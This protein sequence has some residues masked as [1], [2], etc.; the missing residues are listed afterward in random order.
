MPKAMP[1]S[2]ESKLVGVTP[3]RFTVL[4]GALS[5]IAG[6]GN[7]LLHPSSAELVRASAAAAHTLGPAPREHDSD[8]AHRQLV[9]R[10]NAGL[11][12][13]FVPAAG[14]ALDTAAA[15]RPIVLPLLTGAVGVAAASL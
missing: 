11:L 15:A 14:R 3:A 5:V 13:A 1:V 7:A 8:G 4:S 2:I 9:K 6:D 10:S 12:Q